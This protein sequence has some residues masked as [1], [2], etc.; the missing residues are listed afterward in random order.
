MIKEQEK[1]RTQGGEILYPRSCVV[2]GDGMQEGFL[3]EDGDTICSQS[4][5]FDEDENY[6]AKDYEKDYADGTCFYTDWEWDDNWG[7]MW[8]KGGTR[9]LWDEASGTWKKEEIE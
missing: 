7:E 3:A 4:C 2:C 9:Y 5:L 8:T 6:T 1:Q